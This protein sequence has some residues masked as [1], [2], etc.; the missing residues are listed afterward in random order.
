MLCQALKI[1]GRSWHSVYGKNQKVGNRRISIIF[2]DYAKNHAMDFYCMYNTNTGY[3][4]E[5]RH[6]AWLHYM[7]YGYPEV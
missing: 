3:M 1:M 6:I 5:M 2:I 4:T 7:Y